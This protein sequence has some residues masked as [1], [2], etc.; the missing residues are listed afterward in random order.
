MIYE[1][2]KELC[3]ANGISVNELE[4]R[5]GVA[6]GYLC[7]VDTHKP[8]ADKMRAIADELKTSVDYLTTGKEIEFTAEMAM[9]DVELSNMDKRVK[10]YALRL[11]ELPKDKQKHIMEL[12][13]ML[14]MERK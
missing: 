2:I 4:K 5:T 13:D 10:E 14:S 1:R 11:N 7:K 9:I 3:K 12:I 6:K 8:S